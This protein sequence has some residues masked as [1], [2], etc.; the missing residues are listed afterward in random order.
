M[1]GLMFAAAGV[2]SLSEWAKLGSSVPARGELRAVDHCG[3]LG[4]GLNDRISWTAWGA[5]CS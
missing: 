1:L 3:L 5:L 2:A 4:D